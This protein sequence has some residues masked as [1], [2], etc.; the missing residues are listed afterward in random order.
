MFDYI[1]LS[2][3]PFNGGYG[4][5]HQDCGRPWI[6]ANQER[7]WEIMTIPFLSKEH[8]CISCGKY[9]CL[10]D[11]IYPKTKQGGADRE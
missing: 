6:Y 11:K 4:L 9:V 10:R 1:K 2:K 5:I 3:T 8:N 7:V